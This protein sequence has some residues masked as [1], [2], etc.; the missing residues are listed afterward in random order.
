MADA[1]LEK[2]M[3]AILEEY[4]SGSHRPLDEAARH[5][6]YLVSKQHARD[7]KI[8]QAAFRMVLSKRVRTSR[9]NEAQSL[10]RYLDADPE[11]S[12]FTTE[13]YKRY[14]AAVRD[15]SERRRLTAGCIK[16]DQDIGL[17]D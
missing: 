2:G 17:G 13:H 1:Y 11:R 16:K 9:P 8:D 10:S 14:E 15:L 5:I 7:F 4:A 6:A 12:E 3:R